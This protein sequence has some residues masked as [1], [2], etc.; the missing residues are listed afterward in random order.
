MFRFG[1]CLSRRRSM[2]CSLVSLQDDLLCCRQQCFVPTGLS[3]C[4]HNLGGKPG[5]SSA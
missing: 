1:D 2:A 4:T 3:V 5:S